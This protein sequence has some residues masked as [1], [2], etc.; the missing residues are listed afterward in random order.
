MRAQ[1]GLF[2]NLL[3]WLVMIRCLEFQ[4]HQGHI[5]I[6]DFFQAE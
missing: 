4:G 1:V 6:C 5:Y 2:H 3:Y